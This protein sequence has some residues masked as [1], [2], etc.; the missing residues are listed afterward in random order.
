MIKNI[1][2]LFQK[3]NIIIFEISDKNHLKCFQD[4]YKQILEKNNFVTEFKDKISVENLIINANNIYHY[5]WKKEAIP[6][7]NTKKVNNFKVF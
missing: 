2:L 1:N 7:T 3:G 5:G 4:I 6:V